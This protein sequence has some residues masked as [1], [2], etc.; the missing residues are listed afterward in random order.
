V[1]VAFGFQD[2]LTNVGGLLGLYIGCSVIS[3]FEVFYFLFMFLCNKMTK[4]YQRV[5]PKNEI[6]KNFSGKEEEN[7]NSEV[8]CE[9]LG[10]TLIEV[11]DLEED[12]E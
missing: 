4:N 5:A 1:S 9:N 10:P 6:E 11:F 2:F 8:L 3:V 12:F 7:S